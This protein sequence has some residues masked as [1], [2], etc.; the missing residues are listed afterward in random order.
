MAAMAIGLLFK[1]KPLTKDCG[2]DPISGERIGDCACAAKGEPQCFKRKVMNLFGNQDVSNP[3]P[4]PTE[5]AKVIEFPNK[6]R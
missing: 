4:A 1:R 6:D 3:S 5:P 2:L